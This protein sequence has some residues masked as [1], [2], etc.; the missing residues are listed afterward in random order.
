[1]VGIV[2]DGKRAAEVIQRNSL[3]PEEEPA[4]DIA[5]RRERRGSRGA[6]PDQP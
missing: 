3:S 6:G 4:T 2:S 5:A 1:V